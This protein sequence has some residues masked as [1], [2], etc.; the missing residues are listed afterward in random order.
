MTLN[1]SDIIRTVREDHNLSE[2]QAHAV[3]VT[4]IECLAKGIVRGERVSLTGLGTFQA[5]IR[6]AREVHVPSHTDPVMSRRKGT[7]KFRPS[8]KLC[9]SVVAHDSGDNA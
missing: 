1:R 2:E 3:V 5:G 8:T 4:V 9:E 7:V 6:E